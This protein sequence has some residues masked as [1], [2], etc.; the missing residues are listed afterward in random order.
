LKTVRWSFFVTQ[1][2]AATMAA[3]A[4]RRIKKF[5]N[6]RGIDIN[7][8]WPAEL[9]AKN[10]TRQKTAQDGVRTIPLLL[11]LFEGSTPI[12]FDTDPFGSRAVAG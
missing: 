10:N 9:I 8:V 3:I 11:P 12:I 4:E 2:Q 5:V 7:H 6:R 1:K